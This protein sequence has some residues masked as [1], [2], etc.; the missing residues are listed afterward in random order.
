MPNAISHAQIGAAAGA[1]TY[2]G[3]SARFKRE[4]SPAEM[5]V[6]CSI[7]LAFAALPDIMEPALTPNHRS[8]AHSVVVLLLLIAFLFWY[9][10]DEDGTR[11][12]FKKMVVASA[13][14]GYLTHLVADGVTPKG[15]PIF[16]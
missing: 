14:V 16:V 6:C 3:M 5:G 9:C 2:V 7:G 15:L 8:I 12:Q 10:H 4:M 13:A 1:A 11:D